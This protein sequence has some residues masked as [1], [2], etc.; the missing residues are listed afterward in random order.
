MA[1]LRVERKKERRNSPP[2]PQKVVSLQKQ[3]EICSCLIT[4]IHPS[5]LHSF[6]N[7]CSLSEELRNCRLEFYFA[8]HLW[9]QYIFAPVKLFF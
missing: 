8:L 2:L 7:R 6:L 1:V 9:G 5:E 4:V 3:C